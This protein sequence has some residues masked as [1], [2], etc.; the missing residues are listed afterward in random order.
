MGKGK[1][2]TPS[3]PQTGPL[4]GR[5]VPPV[6]PCTKDNPTP[7]I[8][9]RYPKRNL[10]PIPEDTHTQIKRHKARV[11]KD[12]ADIQRSRALGGTADIVGCIP[13]DT[14]LTAGERA[15]REKYLLRVLASTDWPEKPLQMPFL[16]VGNGNGMVRWPT[17]PRYSN[18]TCAVDALRACGVCSIRTNTARMQVVVPGSGKEGVT[19]GELVGLVREDIVLEAIPSPTPSV[20]YCT[21]ALRSIAPPLTP[22]C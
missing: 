1:R 22:V 13:R 9:H 12:R 8:E 2:R 5:L 18:A 20:F 15:D 7:I 14:V 21:I 17:D 6:P 16:P 4:G 10:T 11:R 19:S 3:R